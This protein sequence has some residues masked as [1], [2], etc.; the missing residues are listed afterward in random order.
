MKL[1]QTVALGRR[2]TILFG[3]ASGDQQLHK[4]Q[5]CHMPLLF[6][7]KLVLKTKTPKQRTAAL[8]VGQEV[9]KWSQRH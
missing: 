7:S 9:I 8:N 4:A 2:L 5:G 3:Q 1:S 6:I